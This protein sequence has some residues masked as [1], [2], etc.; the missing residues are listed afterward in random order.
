MSSIL[1]QNEP[2]DKNNITMLG[3]SLWESSG[4]RTSFSKKIQNH[5][6]GSLVYKKLAGNCVE[7]RT[8]RLQC[9][10]QHFS[11]DVSGEHFAQGTGTC[12]IVVGLL[13]KELEKLDDL[14]CPKVQDLVHDEK[15]I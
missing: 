2:A 10:S 3:V 7:Q 11:R 14:G 6:A 13:E 15:W 8:V 12:K 5:K 9:A 1:L 4:I